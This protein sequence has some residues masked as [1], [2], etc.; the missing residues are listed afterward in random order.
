VRGG[1]GGGGVM[2]NMARTSKLIR[3]DDTATMHN[4]LIRL[5]ERAPTTAQANVLS[6]AN[7]VLIWATAPGQFFAPGV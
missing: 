7:Y 3:Q 5:R 2:E 6:G 1:G 4:D